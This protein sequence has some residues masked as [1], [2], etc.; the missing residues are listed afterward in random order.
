M[1]IGLRYQVFAY[2][3]QKKKIMEVFDLTRGTTTGTIRVP[4]KAGTT[5]QFK[6]RSTK[7]K[8]VN[9]KAGTTE[10]IGFTYSYANQAVVRASWAVDPSDSELYIVTLSVI[11]TNTSTSENR[12]TVPFT[13]NESGNVLNLTVI[14]EANTQVTYDYFV[15][16]NPEDGNMIWDGATQ[17][18]E[19]HLGSTSNALL[20]EVLKVGYNSMNQ[21]VSEELIGTTDTYEIYMSDPEQGGFIIQADQMQGNDRMVI[22]TKGGNKGTCFGRIGVRFSYGLVDIVN[23]NIIELYQY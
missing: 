7:T 3:N 5:A 18:F 14:Q 12:T 22:S 4:A 21:V 19:S 11:Y 13:Q 1:G 15:V 6:I 16:G 8:K 23:S 17:T 2:I 20:F 9:G 10:R